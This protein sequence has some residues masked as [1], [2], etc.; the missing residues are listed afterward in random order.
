VPHGPWGRA[1]LEFRA[2]KSRYTARSRRSLG[3]QGDHKFLGEHGARTP[4]EVVPGLLLNSGN[5]IR[6]PTYQ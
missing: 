5:V 4:F 6:R 1:P 2:V 3:S